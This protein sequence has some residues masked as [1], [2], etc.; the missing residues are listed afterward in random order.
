MGA[1][2]SQCPGDSALIQG[3]GEPS[4]RPEQL[5]EP[6]NS[7][8]ARDHGE[9]LRLLGTFYNRTGLR[10]CSYP[11]APGSISQ[12]Q[13]SPW[14]GSC[15]DPAGSILRI[16]L[17]FYLAERRLVVD[18]VWAGL[19]LELA[20]QF[21]LGIKQYEQPEFPPSM[22]PTPYAPGCR[23]HV[24]HCFPFHTNSHR[25]GILSDGR[26]LQAFTHCSL[27]SRS[28][29]PAASSGLALPPR[30]ELGRTEQ[31]WPGR[32]GWPLWG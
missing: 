24:S 29:D 3:V 7:F 30:S 12:L 22:F 31:G 19:V 18:P 15:C 28:L 1:A 26:V 21:R 11:A 5:P 4:P 9:T 6:G 32:G 14:F 10:G 20:G 16:L 8:P 13:I 23:L 2:Q 27:S 25:T 17:C